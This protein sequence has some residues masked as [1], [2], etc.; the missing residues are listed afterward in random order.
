MWKSLW[1]P[2][3]CRCLVYLSQI[4]GKIY[5]QEN[6]SLKRLP[7]ADKGC[8]VTASMTWVLFPWEYLFI[9]SPRFPFMWTSSISIERFSIVMKLYFLWKKGTLWLFCSSCG[10]MCL[11]I[12]LVSH[13]PSMLLWTYRLWVVLLLGNPHGLS[14]VLCFCYF[15]RKIRRAR[16]KW[17]HADSG[18]LGDDRHWTSW[19]P[20]LPQHQRQHLYQL[21]FSAR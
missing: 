8:N 5:Y 11:K 20:C 16:K 15:M 18:D 2:K 7:G 21:S 4:L 19:M 1:C 14:T 9:G 12:V 6:P 13:C 17:I 10:G 3:P